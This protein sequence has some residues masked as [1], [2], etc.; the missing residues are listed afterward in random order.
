M[1]NSK[2][3]IDQDYLI[4]RETFSESFAK[5]L[6][7]NPKKF[8]TFKKHIA[9]EFN[10]SKDADLFLRNLKT[11]VIAQ[12]KA[13]ELAKHANISRTTIYKMLSEK[14]NPSFK[15]IVSFTAGLGIQLKIIT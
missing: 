8:K 10:K 15:S 14:A 4:E 12:G 5:I 1:K 13:T 3:I 2:K 11:L 7:E 6:G 9:D